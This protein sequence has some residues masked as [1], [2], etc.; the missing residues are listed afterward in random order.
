[1]SFAEQEGK[2]RLEAHQVHSRLP[3]HQR[4]DSLGY[5]GPSIP[6]EDP[7][8]AQQGWTLTL[9]QLEAHVRENT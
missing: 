1:M 2:T 9:N 7:G 8:G 4:T 3:A 6:A 5:D